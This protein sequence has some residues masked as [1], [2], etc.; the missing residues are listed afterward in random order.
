MF[1]SEVLEEPF[2]QLTRGL[3]GQVASD[4]PG[5]SK[6]HEDDINAILTRAIVDDVMSGGL[7]NSSRRCG[8]L[9]RSGRF[10]R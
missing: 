4:T 9:I 10:R 8:I 3:G 6:I 5:L 2:L 7:R 1:G